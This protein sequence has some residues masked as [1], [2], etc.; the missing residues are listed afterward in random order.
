M[1]SLCVSDQIINGYMF[2]HSSHNMQAFIRLPVDV[3]LYAWIHVGITWLCVYTCVRVPV[4][5]FAQLN[6]FSYTFCDVY[7]PTV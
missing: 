7:P 2:L 5:V 6:D 3:Y 4:F 1:Y